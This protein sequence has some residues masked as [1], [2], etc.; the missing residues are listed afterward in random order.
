MLHLINKQPAPPDGREGFSMFLYGTLRAGEHNHHIIEGLV[1]KNHAVLE[2][3]TVRLSNCCVVDIG[4]LPAM[5]CVNRRE[6][7]NISIVGSVYRITA[8]ARA[9]LDAFEGHPN[10]YRRG[11]VM[12]NW[13]RQG[14]RPRDR[15]AMAYMGPAPGANVT[16][17]DVVLGNMLV[18]GEGAEQI[19]DWSK[20][21]ELGTARVPVYA[22]Q[23]NVSAKAAEPNP[24]D[25]AIAALRRH[26]ARF[27]MD[28]AAVVLNDVMEWNDEDVDVLDG[29][30][31]HDE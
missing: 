26:G 30:E 21:D 13:S 14:Q 1:A 6:F 4:G 31:E 15:M 24:V 16:D 11:G 10:F 12:G 27:P 7:P 18:R 22:V 20:R 5:Y 19:S 23:G 3:D 25:D 17:R 28:G 9:L 29:E 8:Q 2:C